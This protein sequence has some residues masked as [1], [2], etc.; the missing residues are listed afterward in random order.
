MGGGTLS[1]TASV[2]TT[3]GG[4]WLM[5]S[6]PS[7]TAPA[8][9]NVQVSSGGLPAGVYR[10]KITLEFSGGVA[11]DLSVL[12]VVTPAA[13]AAIGSS[14]SEQSV[15]GCSS[16]ELRAVSTVLPNNFRLPVGWPVPIAV[17]VVDNCANAITGATVVV[18]FSGGDPLLVLKNLRNGLYTGTWVPL[19][20][21]LVQMTVT[22]RDPP[23]QEATEELVGEAQPFSFDLP[24]I[25]PRGVVNAAS[26]ASEEPVAPGSIISLFGL[27]LATQPRQAARP[28]PRNLEGLAV[29][30]GGIDT[31]L[32]YVGPE[33]VNAQVPYELPTNTAVAVVVTVNGKVSPPGAILIS[34]VQPGVFSYQ[35]GEV[36]RGA[37][38][39]EQSRPVDASNPAARGG[40]IQ[41]FAT[42]L[43]DTDQTVE[44][45]DPA[46]A[47]PPARI[48]RQVEVT[49]G[50]LLATV[51]FA[52][53]APGFTGLYQVN[54]MVP[55][56]L[57]PGDA[58]LVLTAL[59]ER[60]VD[61]KVEITRISS[62]TVMVAV[63]QELP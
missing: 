47:D 59:F 42:G 52:G 13:G 28:L 17:R 43:G 45:G 49:I 29:K 40:V 23:L 15:D 31:P 54:A 14:G 39:D 56:G 12:L 16:T 41:I 32:F 10:G 34:P 33:Q 50:G 38:L 60:T 35:D 46:P 4:A 30:I 25:Y 53:L 3:D 55:S 51:H 37:V 18:T 36:T 21:R 6:P 44:T 1:F 9:V 20:S 58:P 8:T 5:A 61:G 27:N 19:S 48:T 2:T 11:Q 7:A 63:K 22:A 24:L 57:P 26:F 62:N